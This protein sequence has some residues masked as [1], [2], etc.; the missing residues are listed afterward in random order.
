MHA[1]IVHVMHA[2]IV[3]VCN[4]MVTT[5]SDSTLRLAFPTA[6]VRKQK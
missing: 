3:H 2:R 4:F 5:E 6:H 1:R